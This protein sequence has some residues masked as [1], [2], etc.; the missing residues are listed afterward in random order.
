MLSWEELESSCLSCNRCGLCQN[1]TNVVFGVGVKTADVM[2][3]GEGPGANED[4]QGI[5]FVGKAG[6]LLDDMLSLIG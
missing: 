6:Q 5:P 1:R 4:E 3:I 2:L